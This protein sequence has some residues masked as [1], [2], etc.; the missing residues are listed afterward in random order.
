YEASLGFGPSI[1]GL[2]EPYLGYRHL[3]MV[4]V[5]ITVIGLVI[6]HLVHGR[7]VK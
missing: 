6:Y 1:I 4:M 3:F 2:F 5:A 7:R